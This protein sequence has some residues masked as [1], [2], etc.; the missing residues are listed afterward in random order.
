[1]R[2]IEKCT[3]QRYRF[4]YLSATCVGEGPADTEP[5]ALE[6]DA[7]GTSA[8][9]LVIGAVVTGKVSGKERELGR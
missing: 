3:F 8:A 9:H 4:G 6:G 7:A 5:S 2:C 1:M